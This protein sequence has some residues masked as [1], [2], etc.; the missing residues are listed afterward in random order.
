MSE[1][2]LVAPLPSGREVA[3]SFVVE[4]LLP[5]SGKV[6]LGFPSLSVYAKASVLNVDMPTGSGTVQFHL[7]DT[8]TGRN[9]VTDFH[10]GLGMTKI[11]RF[12][13]R[14]TRF[15]QNSELY[16]RSEQ[17]VVSYVFDLEHYRLVTKI[18]GV[19]FRLLS[20]TF[21]EVAGYVRSEHASSFRTHVIVLSLGNVTLVTDLGRSEQ[22][23]W[24]Q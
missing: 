14:I 9:Y 7:T 10:L 20:Q 5:D 24:I 17:S 2:E 8:L 13:G 19:H 12:V 23:V 6:P 11:K 1:V 21:T 3:L 4:G 15:F 16:E 18:G 22:F